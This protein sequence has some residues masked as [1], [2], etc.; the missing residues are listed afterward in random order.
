[1]LGFSFLVND[2]DG[3]GRVGWMELTEGIGMSKAPYYYGEIELV[4]E[5]VVGPDA[6]VGDDAGST[7]P[8]GGVLPDGA[9]GPDGG[10]AGD[11]SVDPPDDDSGCSCRTGNPSPALLPLLLVLLLGWRRRRG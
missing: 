5:V 9:I 2:A 3:S 10:P 11:G 1:M 7:T 4:D 6:G 8:D